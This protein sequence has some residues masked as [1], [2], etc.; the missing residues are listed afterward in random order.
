MNSEGLNAFAT[1]ADEIP[2]ASEIPSI[3][4]F[5]EEEDFQ[6][7]LDRVLSVIAK[8]LK[9][10]T[11]NI[12]HKKF[13][14]VSPLLIDVKHCKRKHVPRL[15]RAVSEILREKGYKIVTC[16]VLLGQRRTFY[17]SVYR[18]ERN[19]WDRDNGCLIM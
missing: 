2:A 6:A 15:S 8:E 4:I 18:P 11:S 3:H 7:T 17:V 9:H 19:R 10:P 16:D 14:Q 12:Y 5:Q 13:Y 1:K